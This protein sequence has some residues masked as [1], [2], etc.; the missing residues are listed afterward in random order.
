MKRWVMWT[1]AIV[2]S[3]ILL[4]GIGAVRA[5]TKVIP[6]VTN[7]IFLID[8]SGSMFRTHKEL[9]ENKMVLAKDILLG[10]NE[11][12]PD[13]GY[14]GAIRRFMPEN[15]LI[16][17]RPFDRSAFG[18]IIEKLPLELKTRDIPAATP[19]GAA[20]VDLSRGLPKFQGKTA[21]IIVSDGEVN[22]GREPLSAALKVWEAFPNVCFHVVSLAE[23]EVGR[24][25]LQDV[26]GVN[27][28]AFA[29]GA[30][31]LRNAAATDEYV[32]RIF[33]SEVTEEPPRATAVP[34]VVIEAPAAVAAAA[35]A[36]ALPEFKII[37]FDFDKTNIKPAELGF[38]KENIDLLNAD[39]N[40]K[41]RLEGHTDW[42]GTV[43]YNQGLSEQR[44]KAVY[45]YLVKEG[46]APERMTTV[47]YGET[48]PAVSN[49]TADGRALNRRV[50]IRIAE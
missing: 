26:A 38:L 27:D 12:I 25:N 49:I 18:K 48:R 33:T 31:L 21:I 46:L 14:T 39:P 44:A 5:E 40:L 11:R 32:R 37:Y 28:C 10:I 7:F 23:S 24:K 30:E 16:G 4:A 29:D 13:L 45:D 3:T 19:L 6:R 9:D 50:E 34:P 2:S 43:Q 1:G 20:L 47:G 41:V 22:Q 36:A 35:P 42:V 15:A 17:P 8:Q